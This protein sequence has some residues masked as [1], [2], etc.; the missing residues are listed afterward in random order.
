MGF[1]FKKISALATSAL[2]VGMTAGIAAAANYP[3][4][5]I[6]D[7]VS[8]VAIVVGTGTGVSI[9]DGLQASSIQTDLQSRM[10]T[11]SEGGG[12]TVTGGDSYQFEKTSTKFHIGNGI[13]D[14][15]SGT[16]TDDNLPDLLASGVYVDA[17]NDEFDYDQEI[18][19]ANLSVTLW[20]DSDY[21]E[22]VPTIGVKIDGDTNILNYTLDFNE[23]PLWDDID[24]TTLPFLGK[25]YYV[26]SHV[27]NTSITLLDSAV[28]EFISEGETKTVTVDGK[29]YE[30]S[31]NFVDADEAILEVNGDLTN[32]V[33]EGETYKL[34]DGTYL[35]VKDILYS[36][37]DTGISSVE[38][39][40]GSGKIELINNSNVEI[41]DDQVND[42]TSVLTSDTSTSGVQLSEI[43]MKWT[44]QDTSF[45]TTDDEL[46]MP[47]FDAV[48]FVYAGEYYPAEETFTVEA[49]SDTYWSL[50]S[51]P[52]KDSTED[53]NLL[54]TSGTAIT[55]LGKDSNNGLITAIDS[56]LTFD[57]DDYDYFVASWSD[58]NDAE[59]YLMRATN[60]VT[61]N[62]ADKVN[63]E[64]RKNKEWTTVKSKAETGDTV[65]IGNVELTLG[66]VNNTA[67]SVNISASPGATYVNFSTLY[68]KD[69]LKV[70]LPYYAGPTATAYGAINLTGNATGHNASS[71]YLYMTEEDQNGVIAGGKTFYFT[72]NENSAGDASVTGISGAS[73]S[74]YEEDDTDKF[75]SMTYGALATKFVWD[76]SNDQ[77]DV[78][79]TYHGDESYVEFFLT[80]PEVVVT[81]GDG[82]TSPVS[83]YNGVVIEDKEVG[84]YST[85]NLIVVGGS[86]INSAAASLVGGNFCGTDWTDATGIGP[87][88]FIIKGYSDTPLTSQLA[89]L[90]AGYEEAD[91]ANAA[92]YLRKQTVDTSK[93]YKGTSSTSAELITEETSE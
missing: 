51:F 45:I 81:P 63:I 66:T 69:G 20:E 52:L 42:L 85:R 74:S 65:T 32:S 38:F 71:W 21:A 31:I 19:V 2:M 39:S 59:S 89:L 23:E 49:G 7:G 29:D 43:T 68:S 70:Y 79:V 16:V 83:S 36:S 57:D 11:T 40:L 48:K 34:S 55:G 54:Y 30:V 62:G 77:Y 64:Y 84:S 9:L 24:T 86:C 10:T 76:K 3:A 60:F 44:P 46:S 15:V 1:N 53:I 33:G 75:I 18:K 25:S 12:A 90:V 28:S 80:A 6:K 41:N 35:G 82:G 92:T 87:N 47:A 37:K 73:S 4:P 26:L 50:K 78:V 27:E 13:R 93:A 72:L 91:T 58:G 22:D 88:Q 17:N 56:D 14:V 5:F 8:N 67:D 61:E